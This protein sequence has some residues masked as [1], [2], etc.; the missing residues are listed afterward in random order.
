[1]FPTDGDEE[2]ERSQYVLPCWLSGMAGGHKGTE[3]ETWGEGEEK[4]QGK[5]MVRGV[6]REES[7]NKAVA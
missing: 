2:T 1:M 6:G 3:G 7:K 4:V 5:K